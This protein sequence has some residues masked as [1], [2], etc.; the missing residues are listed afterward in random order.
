MPTHHCLGA[1]DG[2]RSQVVLR[3]IHDPKLVLLDRYPQFV[4]VPH[5]IG[6]SHRQRLVEERIPENSA[7]LG[8]IH[9]RIGV[10]HQIL[11]GKT[12]CRVHGDPDAGRGVDDLAIDPH[13][14]VQQPENPFRDDNGF[15]TSGQLL[16][17]DHELVAADSTYGVAVADRATQSGGDLDQQVVAGRMAKGVVD[18][19]EAI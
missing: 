5:A 11:D 7:A 16:T 8:Q 2:A 1:D 12:R 19:L 14:I 3:L 13:G 9:R 18:D 15:V 17:Q 10:G 6:R 4:L